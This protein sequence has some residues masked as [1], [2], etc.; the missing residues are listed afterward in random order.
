MCLRH[1]QKNT[2]LD[3]D[4]ITALFKEYDTDG[5]KKITKSEFIELMKSTG[6]FD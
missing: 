1:A 4:E 6:A 5:D 3:K 2:G